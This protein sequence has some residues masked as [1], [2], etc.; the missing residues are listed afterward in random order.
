MA[1]S[2]V[3]ITKNP[4]VEKMVDE[5]FALM[6][7]VSSVIRP[8]S[9]VVLKPNAGHP[10]PPETSVCTAPELVAAAIRSIRKA[11]PKEII[12]AEAAATSC[13]TD[14]CFDVSGIRKAAEEAGADKI[15]DMKKEKDLIYVPIRNAVSDLKGVL[16]PKFLIE[17][18]HLVNMPVFKS[19]T[20]MIYTNCLKNIK[21][22]VQDKV[23]RE[24]HATDL[25]QAMF[26]V[27]TVCNMDLQI[28]D[29]YRPAEGF[30]PHS[31]IPVD[32]G[33]VVMGR[34]PVAVDAVCCRMAG[35]D[36]NVV[37]YFK[38]AHARGL[39][40]YNEK[41][42]DVRGKS[43]AEVLRPMWFPFLKGLET[44]PEYNFITKGA[45]STCLSLIA[46]SMDQLKQLGEYEKN[47][48]IYI[49]AGPRKESDF[50]K[51]VDPKDII[52]V[53]NCAKKW[54]DKGIFSPGC[55]PNEGGVFRPII[56][57]RNMED[58]MNERM[59]TMGIGSR[60]AEQC[61]SVSDPMVEYSRKM[62]E[63]AAKK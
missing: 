42:I 19:H 57:R 48:G 2:V 38:S 43:I 30:G 18:D 3:T 9:T 37:P 40:N 53:G 56:E 28:A 58:I 24:M 6:G 46:F 4:D 51:G 5:G 31:T 14:E 47:A 8:N 55:P 60:S 54:A 23:H 26:D 13:D 27:W 10:Y 36:T 59:K 25:A 11:N 45:C 52:I 33:C 32:F 20:C 39:G 34:D 62:R 22:L 21:G 15:I 50:P 49:V 12:V 1:K 61:A 17:A 35:L 7:G 29:M 41:Q 63:Q 44:W 16:L